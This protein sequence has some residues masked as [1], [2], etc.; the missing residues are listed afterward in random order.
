MRR[1]RHLEPPALAKQTPE[2]DDASAPA[3]APH[4]GIPAHV[5]QIISEAGE[6]GAERLLEMLDSPK[7]HDFPPSARKSLIELAMTRAYGLPVRRSVEV[8]LSSDDA[9]AVAA[10]LNSLRD[11]LPERRPQPR[12]VTPK[13]ND[14]G[15]GSNG[16]Q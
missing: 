15:E 3:V 2:P 4:D 11:S 10:S 16:A 5:W 14:T 12:D 8:K 6:R 7:F 13:G 9:D 1:K